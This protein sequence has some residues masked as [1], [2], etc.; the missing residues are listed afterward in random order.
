MY[1]FSEFYIGGEWVE[2]RPLTGDETRAVERS[3]AGIED[4]GLREAALRAT[5]RDLEWK[6]G[7]EVLNAAEGEPG[8]LS[9]GKTGLKP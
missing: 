7:L 5:I 1:N 2:P 9:G 8:G 4:E 6:K 3:V